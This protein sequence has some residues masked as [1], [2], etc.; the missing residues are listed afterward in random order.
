MEAA[1]AAA[2]A[3]LER[4]ESKNGDERYT[5]FILFQSTFGPFFSRDA[6]RLHFR[7]ILLHSIPDEMS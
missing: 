3:S 4:D 7:P 2:K 6:K 1:A 5:L